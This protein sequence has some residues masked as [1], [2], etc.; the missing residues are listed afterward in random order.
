[1]LSFGK[2]TRYRSPLAEGWARL[3]WGGLEVGAWTVANQISQLA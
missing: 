3:G 1:M 2:E